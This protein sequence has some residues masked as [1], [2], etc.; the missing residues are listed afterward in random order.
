MH[1]SDDTTEYRYRR[2]RISATRRIPISLQKSI[3]FTSS[4]VCKTR[5][6]H[7]TLMTYNQYVH[8]S[9]IRTQFLKNFANYN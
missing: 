1:A 8:I 3:F 5:S 9:I 6:S 2:L 7:Y 4:R